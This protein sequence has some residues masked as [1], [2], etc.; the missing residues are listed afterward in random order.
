ML[1]IIEINEGADDVAAFIM[2]KLSTQGRTSTIFPCLSLMNF[3][4]LS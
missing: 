3:I 2:F 1:I 4:G